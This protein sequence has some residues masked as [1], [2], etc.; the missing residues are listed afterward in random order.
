[1]AERNFASRTIWTRDCL[2]VMRGMNSETVDLI[3]LDPPFNSNVD[4]AAPIGSQ[5]AGA[6]FRDMW[7]LSDIDAE[8][9]ELIEKPQP[10]LWRVLLAAMTDSDKSY[11]TYMAAR[12]ME[13][14][15]LLKPTGTIYL[16]CDPKMSHYLKLVM[17]AIFGP[18]NFRNEIVWC[19]SGGGQP[20]SDFPRKHDLIFRYT[21]S[22]EYTFNRDEMR[23][24]YDSD[25]QA[26]VFAGDD[27]RAPGR[28]Y[29]PHPD[30]KVVEDWW[31]GIARPYGKAR[32]GYPTQ[33]PLPLL[34]RIIRASTNP[35]DTV[36]DPFCGCATTCV[37]A[38]NL[39]RDW[40]GIDLSPRAGDLVMQRLAAGGTAVRRTDIIL[41][42]DIPPRTD[43]GPLP[44]YNSPEVKQQLYG[45]QGGYCNGCGEHFQPRNFEVDHIIAQTK[46]GTDQI[47]NLQ[48]LCG[49]CNR[50]KGNRGME[51]LR[52]K[53]QL[54]R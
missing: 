19:Y 3:Y 21:A 31:R 44:R 15:R 45:Q 1:M 28:T 46:G 11:L 29:K 6:G 4:Y 5:A 50:E 18:R 54:T 49:A 23:I 34:D 42:D 24:P 27:T 26:T 20:K 30:G 22:D 8:W 38:E 35:G 14:P 16:H 17:D 2:E 52:S 48:L 7:Y 13:M 47:A 32:T 37:A 25:Y 40:A 39:G 43:L 41:R 33:K 12:L 53:L 10:R 51:Y 36:L 9:I